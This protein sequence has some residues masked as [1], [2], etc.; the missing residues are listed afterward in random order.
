MNSLDPCIVFVST[1]SR[2]EAEALAEALVGEG[3]AACCSVIGDV[4]SWYRW[5]GEIMKDGEV[6]LLCKTLVGRFPELEKRIRA[7]HSYE[8]PEIIALPVT[9]GSAPYLAWLGVEAGAPLEPE[10]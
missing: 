7:V 9:A 5:R 4:T 10:N 3:L 2:Q 6:L 8:I 1:A